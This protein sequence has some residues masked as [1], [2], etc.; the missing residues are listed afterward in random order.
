MNIY[1]Q[2]KTNEKQ[3]NHIDTLFFIS[4]YFHVNISITN[5]LSHKIWII[6]N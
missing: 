4:T 3:G 1:H 5:L 6:E 2:F